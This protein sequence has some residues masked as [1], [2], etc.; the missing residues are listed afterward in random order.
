MIGKITFAALVIWLTIGFYLMN[1]LSFLAPYRD[2]LW[3]QY[4]VY[5]AG[6]ATALFINIYGAMFLIYWKFLFKDTGKKLE[7]LE[8]NLRTEDRLLT[9]IDPEE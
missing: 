1:E 8:K 4:G 7:Q 3:N 5:I 9:Q 6:Y 2:A